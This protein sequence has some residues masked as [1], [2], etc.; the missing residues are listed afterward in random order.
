VPNRRAFDVA[1]D[2]ALAGSDARFSVLLIDV[3]RF[4][5]INDTYGHT[6][7]DEVLC[8]L[9]SRVRGEIRASDTIARIG[10]DELA[11][12]APGASA[13]GA[14]RLAVALRS[15]ALAVRPVADGE[16]VSLTIS[17]A[18]FPEDGRDRSALLRA[19]D[20]RLHEVKDARSEPGST[21]LNAA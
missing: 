13:D 19:A 6:V 11:V 4:K 10:G 12:V 1:L 7:G 14:V 21:A 18:T 16:P 9:A 15:A 5:A 3:D 17:C 20:Q 8:A 2:R